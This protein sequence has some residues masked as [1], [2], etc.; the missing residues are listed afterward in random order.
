M[1]FATAADPVWAEIQQHFSPQEFQHPYEMD[2]DFLRLLTKIRKKAGVPFR[3]ISDARD[4]AG[5]VG[6]TKSAHKKRPCKA[7]DLQVKNSYERARIVIAAIQCGVT[8]VGVYPGGESDG[9]GLHIDAST[10]VDNPSPRI[11]TRY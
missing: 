2:A 6:A 1:A 9:G 8:R 4:P 7:V 11:W 10:H 3:V 5:H